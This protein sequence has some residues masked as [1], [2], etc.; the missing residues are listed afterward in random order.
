MPLLTLA[1]DCHIKQRDIPPPYALPLPHFLSAIPNIALANF[2]LVAVF[3]SQRQL[4]KAKV[5]SLS[6]FFD[7]CNI[8]TQNKGM[9]SFQSAPSS[10]RHQW[11]H[12]YPW[13]KELGAWRN[14]PWRLRATHRWIGGQWRPVLL[15]VVCCLNTH[16]TQ[17]CCVLCQFFW[18]FLC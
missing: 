17:H 16:N 7:G 9:K 14:F 5:P 13:R 3:F 11:N 4:P 12:S 2:W 18:L 15:C 1:A 8:S 6:H 10:L